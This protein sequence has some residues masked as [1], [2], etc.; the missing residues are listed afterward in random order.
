M[1]GF[2]KVATVCYL[3]TVQYLH[4]C[5][6]VRIEF[7]P[8][9]ARCRE[10]GR[11]GDK[12]LSQSGDNLGARRVWF[13]WAGRAWRAVEGVAVRARGSRTSFICLARL[14]P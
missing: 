8:P 9:K 5:R 7:A 2:E 6:Q 11:Y 1:D 12:G 13:C 14:R 3:A 10:F 4:D